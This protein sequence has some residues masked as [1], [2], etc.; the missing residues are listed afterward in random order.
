MLF[1]ICKS[2][3]MHIMQCADKPQFY[4]FYKKHQ[5]RFACTF[6]SCCCSNL[7]SDEKR[8]K[9][10]SDVWP[11][12]FL[13]KNVINPVFKFFA[14]VPMHLSLGKIKNVKSHFSTKIFLV[15]H[16]NSGC[17]VFHHSANCWNAYNA[18][19]RQISVDV[20]Y[21]KNKIEVCL[22]I[23]LYAFQWICI[24]WITFQNQLRCLAK[25]IFDWK[26]IF[27]EKISFFIFSSDN[28]MQKNEIFQVQ[29]L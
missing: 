11:K 21:K 20:S 14:W 10:Y 2:T 5:L 13:S 1:T 9:H 29:K 22:H 4:F 26:W 15:R 23:A 27:G 25:N 6:W 18:M 19:C 8:S 7:L 12:I 24:Q 28:C 16:L 3:E 17:N